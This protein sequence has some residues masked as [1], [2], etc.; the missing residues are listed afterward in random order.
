MNKIKVKF[1]GV[2][3]SFPMPNNND[4]FGGNTS[5][6]ELRTSNNDL[7]IFDM[8]TGLRALGSSL[9]S[10]NNPP[11]DINIILSHY[12]YDHILG[13]LMFLP[14]FNKQF[15]INIYGK[16]E[17]DIDLKSLFKEFLNPHFW[18]VGMEM[19]EANINFINIK[20][21]DFLIGDNVNVKTNLHGHPGGALSLRVESD[22]V[23]VVY[24]TDC[25]HPTSNLN[26][27]VIDI[28]S[29]ADL[30]IHD[31]QYTPEQME[32][33]KGWGHSSWEQACMVAKEAKVNRLALF[34]HNPDHGNN[35][36]EQIES[37]AKELFPNSISAKEGMEINL[38][39]RVEE[40][41][42]I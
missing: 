38:P 20:E 15:N 41:A 9:L 33:H 27:N 30:L 42:N 14:L 1:W 31:A 11:K 37:N 28:S 26:Q 39:A 5:C 40:T 12:H 18:P 21:N 24:I 6:V 4:D 8:G 32:N 13:F 7:V 35:K 34:H 16:A 29:N 22:D 19:F 3:G 25:E 23:A 17:N 2:R 36:L 10:E